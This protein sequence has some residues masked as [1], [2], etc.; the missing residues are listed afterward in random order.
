MNK[1]IIRNPEELYRTIRHHADCYDI[2]QAKAKKRRKFG[3][4]SLKLDDVLKDEDGHTME[5]AALGDRGRGA[6]VIRSLGKEPL[7]LRL[8]NRAYDALDAQDKEIVDAL[9]V[10]MRPAVAAR[11]ANTNRQRVYRVIARFRE[12]LIPAFRDWKSW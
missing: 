8:F 12:L 2:R 3:Y 5:N 6:E 1:L 10:D 9:F 4:D 7:W 11:I